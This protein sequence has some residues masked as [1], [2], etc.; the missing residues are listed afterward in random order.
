M[1]GGLNVSA[2]SVAKHSAIA[3]FGNVPDNLPRKK[4]AERSGSTFLTFFNANYGQ[5]GD[6]QFGDGAVFVTPA[7]NKNSLRP[8]A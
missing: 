3:V 2:F 1:S 7:V 5:F 4:T 8:Q 6:G